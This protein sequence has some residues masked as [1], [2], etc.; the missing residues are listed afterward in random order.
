MPA[1]PAESSLGLSA[2]PAARSLSM[3]ALQRTAGNR[4]V[5]RMSQANRIRPAARHAA[6]QRHSDADLKK[7]MDPLVDE[8]KVLQA[9]H[10]PALAKRGRI[11][12][13]PV[14]PPVDSLKPARMPFRKVE[15][16]KRIFGDSSTQASIR[17]AIR[18]FAG[19]SL[20]KPEYE[21]K[22][23]SI[24]GLTWTLDDDRKQ[25]NPAQAGAA[26]ITIWYMHENYYFPDGAP[27]TE[28]IKTVM[29]HEALHAMSL[30]STGYQDIAKT[31][32]KGLNSD[33]IDE[34]VTD[35]LGAELAG[36]VLGGKEKYTSQYWNVLGRKGLDFHITA[37]GLERLANSPPSVWLGD[38]IDIV[39][40]VEPTLSWDVI[41]KAYMSNEGG[42]HDAVKAKI[43]AKNAE[44]ETAWTAKRTG[45]FTALL[46]PEAIPAAQ[47][48]THLTAAVKNLDAVG[49]P[50][51]YTA[52]T[53]RGLLEADLLGRVGAA[54]AIV[55]KS[56]R[57]SSTSKDDWA[58][59]NRV[60]KT[61]THVKPPAAGWKPGG[62]GMSSSPA[63]RDAEQAAV[64]LAAA[65][66]PQ[67]LKEYE[68]GAAFAVAQLSKHIRTAQR[69]LGVDPKTSKLSWVLIP[70]PKAPDDP[71]Q[72]KVGDRLNTYMSSAHGLLQ[73]ENDSQSL[74]SLTGD[75][76][77]AFAHATVASYGGAGYEA[78]G[79]IAFVTQAHV[80]LATVLHEMGHH[81]QKH[82]GLSEDTV[83]G[84]PLLLDF[85]NVI[86]N[87]NKL[88]A[89]DIK[90]GR[91]A[92]PY[93]RL[94]YAMDPARLRVSQWL[95]LATAKAQKESDAY[96][97]FRNRLT[98]RGG[99]YGALIQDIETELAT[100][101]ALYPG[102]V[103]ILFKNYMM[104]EIK[105]KKPDVEFSDA[106]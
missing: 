12:R 78:N 101:A 88:A 70:T 75:D 29:L 81:K 20:S 45:A 37:A 33:S 76:P 71:A 74:G 98:T 72:H 89:D 24:E 58:I 9:K 103:A 17:E 100:N 2:F 46:G 15:L 1:G 93:V 36:D 49:V 82:G 73:K 79:D 8:D 57:R 14:Q 11:Q 7:Q 62:T 99:A 90:S 52:D 65:A 105:A 22:K 38:L 80:N 47:W 53:V 69:I 61:N 10:D 16:A 44:I 84:I 66:A 92:D 13:H 102:N 5:S 4:A 68:G 56:D 63:A 77:K 54:H 35:R 83:G 19:R 91:D 104:D 67:H 106:G 59:V 25:P 31:Y 97:A 26:G 40:T 6:V 51:T 28:F 50:T 3:M 87:E 42:Q 64:D 86:L 23:A 30:D 55:A 34:A 39:T 43:T 32:T 95:T 48:E 21:A 94:R 85:H 41:K 60:A 18:R 27:R 96:A